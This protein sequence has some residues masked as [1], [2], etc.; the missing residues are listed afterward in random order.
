MRYSNIK[1][2][3]WEDLTEDGCTMGPAP[4]QTLKEK[5]HTNNGELRKLL[6]FICTTIAF[7]HQ[8]S[9]E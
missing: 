9:P 6:G 1:L 2:D 4:V 8:I 3:L 5:I 7:I